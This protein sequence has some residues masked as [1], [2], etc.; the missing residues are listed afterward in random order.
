MVSHLLMKLH[1]QLGG[2]LF[3]QLFYQI[4]NILLGVNGGNG[5]LQFDYTLI[6]VNFIQLFLVDPC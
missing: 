5:S 2:L 6:R 4:L 1:S 3:Q